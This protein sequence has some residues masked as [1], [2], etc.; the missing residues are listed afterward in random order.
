MRVWL[1][2]D[3]GLRGNYDLL[4]EW[5][6]GL[7]AEECGESVATFKTKK[8]C[9]KIAKELRDM[10]GD[11]ARFYLIFRQD[12]K[13]T[14]KFLIGKRKQPPWAGFSKAWEGMEDI[15]DI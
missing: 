13:L 11:S 15:L 6:D 5:L 12:G 3:L 4:Y 9:D 2:Y 14:G 1:S 10:F 7:K 8:Q